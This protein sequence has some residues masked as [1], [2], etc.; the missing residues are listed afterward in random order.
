MAVLLATG[1]PIDLA[2]LQRFAHD[3]HYCAY[4]GELQPAISVTAHAVHLLQLCGEDSTRAQAYMVAHQL[5]DGRWCDDKWNGSWLYTTSQ[6]LIALLGNRAQY[7]PAV[8]RAVQALLAYQHDD[9]GWSTITHSSNTEE[10]AYGILALR[11][12]RHHGM[13]DLALAAALRRAEHWMLEN[14]RPFAHGQ[15]CTW[16]AK[17]NYRPQ[18]IVRMLELVATFPTV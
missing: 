5:P 17:E 7:H 10:T 12:V 9:G 15:G 2:T 11:S 18:R 13:D 1:Y 3:D 6:V 16:L 4:V 14:Y 8:G